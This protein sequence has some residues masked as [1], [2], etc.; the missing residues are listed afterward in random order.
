[1]KMKLI[2]LIAIIT[3]SVLRCPA[4]PLPLP[5]QAMTN[6]VAGFKAQ[7]AAEEFARTNLATID[8]VMLNT[9]SAQKILTGKVSQ[10]LTNY[11]Y[12]MYLVRVSS[13]EKTNE[14]S[15]YAFMS[16]PNREISIGTW[17]TVMS[18]HSGHIDPDNS[19][20]PASISHIAFRAE[21]TGGF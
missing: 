20:S 10:V 14:V 16:S 9:S 5:Y 8:R 7:K 6:M 11:S 2:A 17:V 15:K 21:Y 13:V 12:G 19:F 3:I 1:M 4:P 18:V